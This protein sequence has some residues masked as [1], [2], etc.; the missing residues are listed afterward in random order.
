MFSGL[1]EGQQAQQAPLFDLDPSYLLTLA[2]SS[3]P[4]RPGSVGVSWGGG[5]CPF[6][7]RKGSGLRNIAIGHTFPV[8]KDKIMHAVSSICRPALGGKALLN[9]SEYFH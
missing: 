2:K 1:A 3:L 9:V 7:S 5:V 6:A 8:P 4:A